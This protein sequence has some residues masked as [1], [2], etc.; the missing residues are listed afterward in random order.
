VTTVATSTTRAVL[1][2]RRPSGD[3]LPD[4]LRLGEI[5]LPEL[6]AGHA[7]VR[8]EYMSLDPNARGRM[9]TGD[10]VYTAN[11]QVDQPLDGW[12]V[13]TVLESRSADLPTGSTVRHRKGYRDL[14]VVS[15]TD[16]RTVDV[17]QAPAAS[18]L[19]ALGQTGFTAYVGMQRVA[20]VAKGETVFVS[21]AGGG[22]G[23]VAGQVARLLGASQVIGSAG[24]AEK[25]AW[26]TESAGYDEAIDYRSQDVKARLGELAPEGLDVYFDNVGGVQLVAAVRSMRP[27]GRVALCGMI[28]SLA[29]A[30]HQPGIGELMDVILRR[31]TIQGFIVRDHEDLRARFEQDVSRWLA[32]GELHDHFTEAEG[33]AAAPDALVGMLG[34][35][36]TGKALVRLG[37]ES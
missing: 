22:V 7:L 30:E 17:S 35:A 32:S 18:W 16:A 36:N 21:A 29:G 4:D 31:V 20:A 15:D 37:G 8:N 5:P 10:M 27:H 12:A 25:C 2:A 13:G 34:G 26:L 24:G 11:F 19:S 33:L 3:L 23:Q 14:A 28:S 6:T 9:N 1:L